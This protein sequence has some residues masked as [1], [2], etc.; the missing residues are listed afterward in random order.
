VWL[1]EKELDLMQGTNCGIAVCTDSNLK[2][3]SGFLP[4]KAIR[5]RGIKAAMASD[6]VASNN[7]LDILEE[8]ST[9]AKLHKA[10]NHD[11]EFLPARDAFAMLTIDAAKAL[12]KDAEVGSL[13]PDKAADLCIIN[14]H[15]LQGQPLYNPYSHLVYALSSRHIRDVMVAGKLVVNE[16]RPVFCNTEDLLDR[17]R[18]WKD[19][20]VREIGL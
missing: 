3:S 8:L 17:A 6:G 15:E 5:E 19:K 12:G 16:Y 13:E 20:I 10:L 1:S 18:Y 9:T 2:L 4:L 7:N 14:T 11:P